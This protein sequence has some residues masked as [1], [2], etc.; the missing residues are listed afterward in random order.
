MLSCDSV[1]FSSFVC[2]LFLSVNGYET[3]RFF[4]TRAMTL[5]VSEADVRTHNVLA[6]QTLCRKLSACSCCTASP[7]RQ[8]YL[9]ETKLYVVLR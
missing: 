7:F 3:N 1:R 5:Q 6:M 9:C 8:R 2:L 4:F